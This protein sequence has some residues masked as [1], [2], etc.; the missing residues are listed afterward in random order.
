LT[1]ELY[2][3]VAV[4]GFIAGVLL[5][6]TWY[7]YSAWGF[8]TWWHVGAGFVAGLLVGRVMHWSKVEVTP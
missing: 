2:S 5:L 8:E 4:R 1:T 7:A 6:G 3:K